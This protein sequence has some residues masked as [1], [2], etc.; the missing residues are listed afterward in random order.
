[1]LVN[2]HQPLLHLGLREVPV[3]RVD[4]LELLPSIATLV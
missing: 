1:M 3:P 4:G 2:L